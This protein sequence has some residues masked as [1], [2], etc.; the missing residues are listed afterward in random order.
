MWSFVA[1]S[2]PAAIVWW[3]EWWCFEGLTVM[4]GLLPNPRANLAAHG[5]MFNILVTFYQLFS[6]MTTA[7]CSI[8]GKHVGA[9]AGE[10]IPATLTIA[11]AVSMVLAVAVSGSLYLL[12]NQIAQFFSADQHVDSIVSLC[13]LGPCLSV[14]GYACL[15]T[16]YGAC[17][18]ANIQRSAAIGTAIGYLCLGVPLAYGIGVVHHWPTGRP[19]LGI[20]LGNASALAWA[21]VWVAVVCINVDWKAVK[22]AKAEEVSQEEGSQEEV[23]QESLLDKAGMETAAGWGEGEEHAVDQSHPVHRRPQLGT[24]IGNDI[25]GSFADYLGDSEDGQQPVGDK[26]GQPLLG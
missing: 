24:C 8:V 12:R 1:I 25:G 22:P 18:G 4:V 11:V 26:L 9:G 2:L 20:W 10:L 19:L 5:A 7:V 16:L 3:I 23:I 15:M 21:A 13:M 6:G 17:L 14:I